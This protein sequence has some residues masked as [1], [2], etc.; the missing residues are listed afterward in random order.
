MFVCVRHAAVP[1]RKP[2]DDELVPIVGGDDRDDG[3]RRL[4]V[5][6]DVRCNRVPGAPTG[7]ALPRGAYAQVWS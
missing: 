5:G 3:A 6:G 4:R 7:D 1:I 2:F